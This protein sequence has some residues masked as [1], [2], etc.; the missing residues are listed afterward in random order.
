MKGGSPLI[1]F[2]FSVELLH[3]ASPLCILRSPPSSS[4][5][6]VPLQV[7]GGWQPRTRSPCTDSAAGSSLRTYLL[8]GDLIPE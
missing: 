3:A 6:S 7:D 8:P 2:S 4:S 1:F 5:S